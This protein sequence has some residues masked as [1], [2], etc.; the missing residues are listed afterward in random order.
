MPAPIS[1]YVRTLNEARLI[2][3]VVE[4]ARQV[5]D[6]VVVIDSGS[7][8]ATVELAEKAGARVVQQAWLGNGKQKR[9]AEDQCTHDWVL[10]LDADEVVPPDLAHEISAL[11]ANGQPPAPIYEVKLVTAPPI[12]E[13]WW[14]FA[15]TDRRKLYDKRVIR[16]PDHMAWD[17]F[18][19]PAGVEVGVLKAPILH[20]SFRDLGHLL[21][22]LN[23]V[24]GVRARETKLK[25]FWIVGM[26]VLFAQPFYFLKYF[27]GRGMWRAGLYGAALAGVVAEGRWL[28]D[29]KMLEIHLQKRTK[30]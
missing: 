9:F 8:D 16:A 13:P 12:G 20:Y 5:A 30:G 26:R 6:E 11:F 27:L 10:D 2:T 19:V 14:T 3:R 4:A 29:V 21:E 25:P 22:K 1:A 23:R 28:R 17:Q 18:E 24:S 7:T 15:L